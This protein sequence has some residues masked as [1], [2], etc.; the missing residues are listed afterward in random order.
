MIKLEKKR[1]YNFYSVGYSPDLN[2]YVMAICTSGS[3]MYEQYFAISEKEFYSGDFEKLYSKFFKQGVNST[4][5]ISYDSLPAINNSYSSYDKVSVYDNILS[6]DK[7]DCIP[8]D[9]STISAAEERMNR[10][11][12]YELRWFYEDVGVGCVKGNKHLINRIMDPAEVAGIMCH[13]EMYD[14]VIGIVLS[15]KSF[16]FLMVSEGAYLVLRED[17]KV[18]YFDKIIA[19]SFFD[20][21]NKEIDHPDYYVLG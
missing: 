10:Q 15:D 6:S 11:F 19:N 1:V 4:R 20:F 2:K 14:N 8:V 13:D 12:P 21:W 16:P 18:S 3:S 17:G 7:L 9:E 5:F